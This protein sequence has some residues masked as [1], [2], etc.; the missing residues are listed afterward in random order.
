LRKTVSPFSRWKPFL[1]Q[2]HLRLIALLGVI[3]PRRLRADWRQEWEAE[4]RYREA[5][6]ADW[7]RLDWR[8]KFDLLARST[9]AFWDALWLQPSRLEDEMLQDV[10]FGWRM[11]CRSPI[12]SLV[13]VFSLTLGIGANTAI[14]CVINA[15]LLRPLPYR[16][17]EQL[18]K[19]FQAQPDQ[20]KG[21][22]ASVWSYPRFQILKDQNQ[23]FSAVA[24]FS[25]GASNLTGTDAPEQLQIEMVSAGYFPLLGVEAA[26]GRTFTSD[27]DGSPGAN[28][29]ALLGYGLWQ[30]RFGGDPQVIG[31][32]IE[33]DEHAFTVVG[34]LPPGFRGQDGTADAWVAMTAAEV[35]RYKGSLTNPRNYWFQVVARLKPGVTLAQA[36]LEM[37]RISEQIEQKFPSPSQT[38]SGNSKI[39]A[40]APLQAAKVDPAIRKSFLILFACVGL[41]L[42]IA[43]ANTASLLLARGVARHREIAVRAALGAGRLRVIRQLLTESLLLAGLGGALGVLVARLGLELL[44]DF[45]PSDNA[46]FW[47]SYTRT[48]DFF[49]INLDWRVLTFNFGLALVTGL[50][51]GLFPAIQSSFANVNQALKDG[52]EVSAV[53]FRGLRKLSARSM[54]VVADITLSLVLLVAAGLM[55]RSLARLQAVTLGFTPDKVLTM[56]VHSRTAKPEFYEQLLERVRAL[57]G[58][59]A[60]SLGSTAPLLGLASMTVMDIED[61]SDVKF[62]AVGLHSV[63]PDYFRTLGISQRMGRVFTEQDRAGAP[64]VALI[65][66]A[67]AEK[68]FAG[69][70]PLGKRIQPYIDPAYQ[71]TEKSVEIVGVVANVRYD[72]LEAPP[73]P[74][75]YLC[76]LQPTD[77]AQTLILRTRLDTG[78][79]TPAVR[80]EVLALD[81]NVPVTAIQTMRERA[82]EVTSRTRFIAVLLALFAGLALLLAAAGIYGVMT[83]SVAARTRELGIRI[84]I[85]ARASDVGGLVLR[86]G[87]A[88]IAAGLVL[89][90]ASAWASLTVLQSQLYEISPND[91]LTL[92]VVALL[93]AV[94]ALFASYLPARKAMRTDPLSALRYE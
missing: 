65:N 74:E 62:A 47:T 91:P 17:P 19:V 42:L 33:F 82:A 58:V 60:A 57:P 61:R 73:G 14:F 89:G 92:G 79:I 1:F 64:R 77:P 24:P 63:S 8:N 81:H 2:P 22:L 84:A 28:L 45:R 70:D 71:T 31:K 16:A 83:Y 30:R 44:K 29:A 15:L 12:I 53:G 50:F 32:T 5:L 36:Q 23:S 37:P 49:A 3:V 85:G 39:P 41:V 10:R 38:L 68:F 67:A 90:L 54:L 59:E 86:Q 35:L 26:V 43:C 11:L 7:D 40:L 25:Q 94:V 52:S 75:V 76:S 51:F 21:G 72:R 87:I 56:A 48:F 78:A 66:Q 80:S 88:L 9:S 18:V 69:D 34:V 13:A 93:L 46:R 20:A 27:E 6:L 4:L 55:L